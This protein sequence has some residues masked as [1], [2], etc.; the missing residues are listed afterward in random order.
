MSDAEVEPG[1]GFEGGPRGIGPQPLPAGPRGGPDRPLLEAALVFGAYY[2]G[3]YAQVDASA[4]G[5]ALGTASYHGRLLVELAPKALLLLYLMSRDEGLAAFGLAPPRPADALRGLGAALGAM[6]IVLPAGLLLR[7]FG[8]SNP[9]LGSTGSPA[10]SPALLVPLLAA[11]SL[12]VGYGEELFFRVYLLRRLGQAGLG[13]AWA[14]LASSLLFGS[15]HG[16]QGLPG[17]AVAACLGLWF[18]WRWLRGRHFHELA[19]GH[20]MYDAAVMAL[21]LSARAA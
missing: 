20:A 4:L 2:L 5:R 19:L 21:A 17:I 3:S 8:W 11:S 16:L 13:P 18:S 15:A 14:A 6:A 1:E 9:L 12:A 10:S 7:A